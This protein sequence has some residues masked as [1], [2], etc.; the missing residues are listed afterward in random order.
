MSFID[1]IWDFFT[2]DIG[3]D[4][5]TANTMVTVKGRGIIIKEPSVVALNKRNKQVLAVG[6]EARRMIGRTPA[7]IVAIK[8]LSDGVI[9]DFDTTEAMIRY[10]IRK[11]HE[12]ES[13]AFK[14]PRPRVVI[15]IPSIVT[16]VEARA[17]ID[18]AL[19]AGARKAY[20]IE[21]PMAASIGAGL[22]IDEASGN[23][24]VD[25]GGGTTDIA[26]ISL[27]GIVVDRTIRIAGAEMDE[28]IVDFARH[29]YNL[30]IGEKTAEDIKIAIGSASS[31]KKEKEYSM[32]GRDL[33]SGLPKV[34]RV[35]S[36]EVREVLMRPLGQ[37]TDAIKDAIESTPPELLSDLLEKGITLAGGGALLRGIDKYFTKKLKTPVNIAED[38]ISCVVRGAGKVLEDIELLSKAQVAGDDLI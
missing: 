21:E 13:R 3:V 30:L 22:S 38:P 33:V 15:G 11:A 9:S 5:G 29:K 4:L 34:I 17:V 14:I 28:E 26:V 24:I 31:L 36:V 32:K 7:N 2:N 35:T 25:I 8:P 12:G 10:F 23:M 20:V 6:S 37:I 18:A 19:S 27:G 1:S 16:E